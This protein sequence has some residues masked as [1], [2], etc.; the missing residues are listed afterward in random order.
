MQDRYFRKGK[1]DDLMTL[2][3]H[4]SAKA[5]HYDYG[6]ENYDVFNE[7]KSQQTNQTIE[8]ILK[9]YNV[10]SVLD[11]T[12]GTGSQVFW[13]VKRKYEV[14]GSDISA[15]MLKVAKRK[16]RAE[17]LDVKF[18]EGDMR[19]IQVGKFDAAI[20]IFNAVG[21]LTKLDFEMAIR[22]IHN[23]LNEDGLYIFDIFNLSYL[24]KGNNITKLTIDWQSVTDDTKIRKIQ[25]STIDN[26]G[27]LASHTTSYSQKGSSP[28]KKATGAKTLQ[29]YSANQLKEM[30]HRNGF[31]VIDQCGIDGLK[32][33]DS[34]SERIVMI[35][36]KE[37]S[38]TEILTP[39]L[40]VSNTI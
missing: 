1:A 30:L 10:K 26:D 29:T 15:N 5:S 22:N 11:L 23:N 2:L 21:H 19:T 4:E 9:K 18:L 24:M 33:S 8:N 17:N 28:P 39:C 12:C 25:Y 38:V 13:L 16:A 32:F 36:K 37:G 3:S 34:K 7:K 14:T 6:A 40:A 31:K 27:I 20:T 35:A